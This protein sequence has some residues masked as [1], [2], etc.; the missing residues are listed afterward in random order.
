LTYTTT[1][2]AKISK[3]PEDK[4]QDDVVR[5]MK[6]AARMRPH[7]PLPPRA[8]HEFAAVRVAIGLGLSYW[9]DDGDSKE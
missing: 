2:D 9:E 8:C 1:N 5:D 6:E 7:G 4:D 3:N